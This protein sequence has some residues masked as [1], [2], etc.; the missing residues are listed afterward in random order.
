MQHAQHFD[1]LA[2][3]S[4][5]HVSQAIQQLAIRQTDRQ[6]VRQP[7]RPLG[8]RPGRTPGPRGGGPRAGVPYRLCATTNVRAKLNTVP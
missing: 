3:L 8:S 1:D 5:C 6:D 7:N 4:N 2:G